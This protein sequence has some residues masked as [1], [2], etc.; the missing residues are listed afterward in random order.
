MRAVLNWFF[1][2]VLFGV[3]KWAFTSF[4]WD[5][6]IHILQSKFIISEADVIAGVSSFIIPGIVAFDTI[7]GKQSVR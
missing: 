6:T 5:T 1:A 3:L 4:A 7:Y 2:I